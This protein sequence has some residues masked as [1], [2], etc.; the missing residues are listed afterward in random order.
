MA[1]ERG[2]VE[3]PIVVSD[4]ETDLDKSVECVMASPV[5]VV[6][7]EMF[8]YWFVCCKATYRNW[9]RDIIESLSMMYIACFCMHGS[10]LVCVLVYRDIVKSL[11]EVEED[12]EG[13]EP[14]C[15]D[16]PDPVIM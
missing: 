9:G 14:E 16:Q 15:D 5:K 10:M 6:P 7:G 13:S 12:S 3:C 4:S 1:A 11:S 2:S 8:R